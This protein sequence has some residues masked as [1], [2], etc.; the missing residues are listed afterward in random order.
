M[1]EANLGDWDI[2]ERRLNP[3]HILLCVQDDRRLLP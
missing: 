3:K 1:P 2:A